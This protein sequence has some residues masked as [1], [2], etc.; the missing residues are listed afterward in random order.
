M[1]PAPASWSLDPDGFV[2]AFGLAV[3]YAASSRVFPASRRRALLFSLGVALV[4]FTRITPLGTISNH[5]LL[6]VHLLQNVAIAEWAPAL[7]VAGL[8]PSL[9]AF[10]ARLPALRVLTRP[11]V[12]LPLWLATYVVWH[13]PWLYD[14]AL[15]HPRSLL[16]LEHLCYL[17]AGSLLWWPVV[18]EAPHR[19]GPGA[20]AV[21]LAAAFVFASPLGLVLSLLGRP[22][23]AFYEHAP[24][25]WGISPLR[26]QR[27]AGVAMTVEEAV[28]FFCLLV[29]Y[30]S[31]FF[32]EEE[33][34]E[35][36][37]ERRTLG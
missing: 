6:S 36:L 15:E 28:L 30:V 3:L 13:L 1:A 29:V 5:Y 14:T 34:P 4:L 33:S 35:A 32:R 24:R 12:A 19:L 9:A 16:H 11:T 31:R 23:Y 26:D 17:A 22:I 27:I 21:Y 10:L 25:L 20:K 2:T 37:V 7:L 8:P 18:Q